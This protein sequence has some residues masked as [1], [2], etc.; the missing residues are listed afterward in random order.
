MDNTS[1]MHPQTVSEA[2]SAALSFEY[3]GESAMRASGDQRAQLVTTMQAEL[4]G[5]TPDERTRFYQN[6]NDGSGTG[7]SPA[8]AI[9]VVSMPPAY[10]SPNGSVER[11]ASGEPTGIVFKPSAITG[12]WD[13]ITNR[14]S[15]EI[16]IKG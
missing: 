5:M 13:A 14:K 15:D 7:Q 3:Q 16:H 9:G 2:R 10:S 11:D 4:Q 6:Y 12:L 1:N 8:L